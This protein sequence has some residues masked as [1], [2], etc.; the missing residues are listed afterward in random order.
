[1]GVV[2]INDVGAINLGIDRRNFLQGMANRLGEKAHE[3]KLHAVLFLKQVLVLFAQIHDRA[4]V[5]LVEGGQHGSA[6]LRLLQATGNRLAQAGH[7]NP[8]L[9]HSIALRRG[10]PRR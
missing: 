9:A 4:H 7:L 5:H 1:M 3:A 8:L 2:F 6:V 10:G